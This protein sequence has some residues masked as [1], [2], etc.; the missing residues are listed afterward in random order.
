MRRCGMIGL[1]PR[2]L[3]FP[4]SKTLCAPVRHTIAFD[5]AL[6]GRY[7]RLALS[8]LERTWQRL[9]LRAFSEVPSTR[10]ASVGPSA[11]D[12]FSSTVLK[13]RITRQYT[14]GLSRMGSNR[15]RSLWVN[16]PPAPFAPQRKAGGSRVAR[17]T[18]SRASVFHVPIK[19]GRGV[20]P[21]TER[22]DVQNEQGHKQ[23]ATDARHLPG[24]G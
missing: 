15:T 24:A 1:I 11:S 5:T 7:R 14:H 23:Q 18:R 6:A 4:F 21:K 8:A 10:R 12:P 22:T 16:G 13:F 3:A 9:S 20:W 19:A 2:L 17:V